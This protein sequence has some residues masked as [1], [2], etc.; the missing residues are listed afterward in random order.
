MDCPICA[1]A[2]LDGFVYDWRFSKFRQR[3]HGSSSKERPGSQFVVF[4]QNHDQVAN[5]LAGRRPITLTLRGLEKVSA[6]LLICA[7][8]LPMLFMGQEYGA[9]TIFTYF[10]DF[11]D[12]DFAK[13]VSEGTQARIRRISRP[14]IYRSAIARGL[15]FLEARLAR[16][17]KAGA[18]GDAQVPSR[19]ART[20]QKS[21]LPF[22]LPQGSHH[23]RVQSGSTL[24]YY[25]TARRV[26]AMCYHCVQPR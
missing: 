23:R 19:P 3:F 25:R 20:A 22:Q 9:E 21:P 10:T 26:W 4:T 2:L 8:N 18:S 13:A 6:A 16:A 12:R 1:K 15:R 5:A 14:G 7:P 24:D 17:G 11:Q